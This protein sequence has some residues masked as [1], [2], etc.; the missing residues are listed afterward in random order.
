MN[1]SLGSRISA[2]YRKGGEHAIFLAARNSG[3]MTGLGS[4][5]FH[6]SPSQF[7]AFLEHETPALRIG[8]PPSA[9][10]EMNSLLSECAKAGFAIEAGPTEGEFFVQPGK[11]GTAKFR[12]F[13]LKL[14][15]HPISRKL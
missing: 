6:T 1:N 7:K 15:M 9:K 3:T 10:N 4:N 11:A 14:W 5:F 2:V 12:A 8:T 13:A